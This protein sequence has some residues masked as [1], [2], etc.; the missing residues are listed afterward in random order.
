MHFYCTSQVHKGSVFL[1]SEGVQSVFAP[2]EVL[3]YF[4]SM[5]RAKQPWPHPPPPPPEGRKGAIIVPSGLA[6][7]VI[8]IQEHP[9]SFGLVFCIF[10]VSL[11][12]FK[13]YL[14]YLKNLTF[15]SKFS[16]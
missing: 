3:R 6:R 12:T 5:Q 2:V 11:S 4:C 7:Y 10:S 13:M 9:L 1:R 8:L 14:I 16:L 15:K